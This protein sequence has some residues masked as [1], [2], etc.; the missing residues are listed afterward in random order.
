MTREQGSGLLLFD[1]MYQ[2]RLQRTRTTECVLCVIK[3]LIIR[4]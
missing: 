2:L 4:N 1:L 3:R